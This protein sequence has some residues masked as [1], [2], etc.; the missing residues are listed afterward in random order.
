MI[1]NSVKALVKNIKHSVCLP[2]SFPNLPKTN[3]L[4]W[5]VADND[6]T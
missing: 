1:L 2:N 6:G 5:N 3:S 4:T